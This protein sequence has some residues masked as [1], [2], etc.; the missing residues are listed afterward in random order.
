MSDTVAG[1]RKFEHD[2]DANFCSVGMIAG[3]HKD[4]RRWR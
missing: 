2:M 1:R 3:E 4:S